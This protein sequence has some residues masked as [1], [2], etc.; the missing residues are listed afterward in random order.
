MYLERT[1]SNWPESVYE[2]RDFSLMQK[3]H[4]L[5][6][7]HIVEGNQWC[8]PSEVIFWHMLLAEWKFPEELIIIQSMEIPLKINLNERTNADDGIQS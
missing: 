5:V 1:K 8:V 2:A 4:K 7:V 3:K 6:N